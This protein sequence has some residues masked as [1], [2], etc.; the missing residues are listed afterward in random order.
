MIKMKNILIIGLILMAIFACSNDKRQTTE[1]EVPNPLISREEMIKILME[2][3]LA[4]SGVAMMAI[5]HQRSIG[6]YKRYHAD[7]MKKYQI[8]TAIYNK[9]YNYYMQKPL[10]MEYIFTM[11]ED[12]LVRVQAVAKKSDIGGSR[13]YPNKFPT[14]TVGQ[15]SIK[16]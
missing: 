7:I 15:D 3:H 2:I 13:G 16:K 11:I 8:D 4:E 10:E 1:V 6:L 5:D 14:S 12:S 9:N